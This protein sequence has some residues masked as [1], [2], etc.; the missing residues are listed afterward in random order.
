MERDYYIFKSGRLQRKDNTLYLETTDE[1]GQSVKKPIP[2]EAVNSIYLM[3]EIDLNTR[4]LDFLAQNNIVLHNFNHYGY[5]SG[6]YYPREYLNSGFLLVKQV[7]HYKDKNMRLK[8]AKE[9]VSS[10]TH[11]I[12][13]NL[14]HYQKQNKKVDTAIQQIETDESKIPSIKDISELMAIEGHIRDTYYQTFNEILK[15]EKEFTK[16]VRRPPDNPVNCLISFGNSLVYTTVLSE[17]YHTHLNPTISFLHEP[18][19]RRFSLSLD[20]AEIFKPILSDKVTFKLINNQM[21][22]P[23]HFEEK[24]NFCYLKEEGRKLYIREFDERLQTTIDHR[25]L[26]RKVSYRHLIR[27]ECYKLTKHILGEKEYKAFRAWW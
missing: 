23:E 13:N 26:K 15:L 20:L 4:L 27:L 22:K 6:S 7:E 19:T 16:R 14:R 5:Y 8:I 2:V 24:L 9:I 1:N 11:N 17:I 3:G 10:A 18:G 25:E 12:K 21:I